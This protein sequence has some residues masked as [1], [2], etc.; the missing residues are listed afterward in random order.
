ML[1]VCEKMLDF[2]Q[3]DV[4]YVVRSPFI[5]WG[6]EPYCGFAGR[7]VKP[8]LV[9]A[10]HARG[11][12]DILILASTA[13]PGKKKSTWIIAEYKKSYTKYDAKSID[14]YSGHLES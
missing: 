2:I 1:S 3:V 8:L 4:L 11:S 10:S 5:F 13:S 7:K 12:L 6:P 14:T 9:E